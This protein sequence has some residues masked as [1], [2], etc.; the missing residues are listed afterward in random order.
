M[1]IG[2]CLPSLGR[3]ASPESLDAA[4]S[5]AVRLGWSSA[6]TT[7]HLLVPRGP[8]A[9]EYGCIL[10]AVTALTYVAARHES[11]TVGFS[12]I[13]PAMRDAPLLAKQLATL[14][15]LT[16]GRLIVG[17]GV[18]D[19]YDLTEYENLGKAERFPR[20]GAYLDEAVELW[21]HLWSGRT[22]PFRGTF[23]TLED[24]HFDPLP[25]QGAGI[26]IWC[27]GRS[28]RAV[29]RTAEL[30]D[31]Y[32]AA[33]TGPVQL[34]ER[35]PSIAAAVER[36]GRPMPLISVRARVRFD[37]EPGPVYTLC[38]SPRD[39]IGDLIAFAEL[40]V[41]DLVVVFDSADPKRVVAQMERFD[42][43]VVGA[44]RELAR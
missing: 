11:L 5:A 25:P 26:P 39:M 32:H 16:H 3:G 6:W 9:G 30:A 8:E 10:E 37:A 14:D 43:D 40:G 18:S 4:A 23:H 12:V 7:D 31:G 24:F 33:Q 42:A 35:L 1:R 17:V 41:E 44:V 22:D 19:K 34:R 27:G 2:I 15:V 36:T 20:R 13:I 28:A 21:R 38:G 29:R